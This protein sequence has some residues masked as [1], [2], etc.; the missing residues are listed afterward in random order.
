MKADEECFVKADEGYFVKA[1]EECFVK[2]DA[3]YFV[4]ADE[5]CLVKPVVVCLFDYRYCALLG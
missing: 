5:G 4:K 1:D 3:G 2:A